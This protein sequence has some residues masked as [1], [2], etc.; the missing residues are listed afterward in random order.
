MAAKEERQTPIN[1]VRLEPGDIELLAEIDRSEHISRAYEFNDGQLT[2]VEVDWQVPNWFTEGAGDHG[3]TEQIAFCRSHLDQGGVLLGALHE[4]LLVG[5]AV[6]RPELHGE[7]AQLAFLHVSR[8]FRRQGIAQKLMGEACQIARSAGARRMYI[9]AVPSDS[10]VDF[11][12][13]QG[14]EL[15]D[16]VDPELYALEPE[17]IHIILDL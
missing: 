14:C 16:P 4:N 8:E 2:L 10:A 6:V 12:L 5:I 7:M 15:A 3:L 17:D 1:Y 11:Y 9:S 13:F